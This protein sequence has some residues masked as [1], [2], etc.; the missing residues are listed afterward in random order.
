MKNKILYT[1]LAFATLVTLCSFVIER[2]SK[3]GAFNNSQNL[4]LDLSSSK[5]DYVQGEI[6]ELSVNLINESSQP[7]KVG[8]TPTVE[9]GFLHIW[10]ADSNQEFKEYRNSGWGL[11]ESGKGIL[12]AGE[13]FKSEAT[14]LWNAKPQTSHLNEDAAKRATEGKISTDYAFPKAG[15]YSIKS[16]AT[17]AGDSPMKIESEPIQIVINEPIG[18]DLKVWNQ[19]KD[20]GDIAYFIQQGGTPT[21]QDEK[22]E[23]LLKEVEQI[24]EK[25]PNSNLAG[26]MKQKL[27]KFRTDEEKRKEMLEKARIKPKN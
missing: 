3:V 9:N 14:I 18:D 24:A 22:T 16:V 5:K 12:K 11:R 15:I 21:Y 10:I 13:S 17:I 6:V 7:V 4:K 19:I 20:N 26:Q 2:A 25:Y 1:F 23:K 8:L 27:E